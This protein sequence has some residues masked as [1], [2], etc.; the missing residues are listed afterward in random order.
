M[1]VYDAH[2]QFMFCSRERRPSAVTVYLPIWHSDV[3]AFIRC[4]TAR[5]PESDRVRNVYPALWVPDAL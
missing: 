4:R 1:K 3:Q 5:A 2:A